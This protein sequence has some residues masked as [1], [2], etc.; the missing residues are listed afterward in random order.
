VGDLAGLGHRRDLAAHPRPRPPA[1]Q[2][3]RGP[4]A[5]R[6]LERHP[7]RTRGPDPVD[8]LRAHLEVVDTLLG[9][10]WVAIRDAREHGY[11][12]AEIA[13]ALDLDPEQA[14]QAYT[15]VVQ[16]QRDLA[17]ALPALGRYDPAWA[18]L[19]AAD[20]PADRHYEQGPRGWE[21]G[22]GR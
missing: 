20:P 19:A 7:E 5:V 2:P 14:R 16:R 1:G 13:A 3:A 22:D 11:S 10:R 9:W 6:A 4:R 8:A 15:T 12:W 17:A 18:E 21:V